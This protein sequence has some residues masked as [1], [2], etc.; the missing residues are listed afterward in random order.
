MKKEPI[1]PVCGMKVDADT[2]PF[3]FTYQEEEYFFCRSHCLEKFKK[4]PHKYLENKNELLSQAAEYTCPMHPQVIQEHPGNCPICGMT[5]EPKMIEMNGQ[6]DSEY[7]NM[8]LRFFIALAITIPLIFFSMSDMFLFMNL[9]F[10]R[11][12]QFVFS[13]P[14][15][16]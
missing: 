11:W 4:D 1:D 13:K 8:L 10:A 2:P 7:K 6:D 3:K 5:L 12:L 15:V 9:K 14:V 16:L